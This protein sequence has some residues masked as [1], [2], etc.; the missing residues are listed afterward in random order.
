MEWINVNTS[1]MLQDA[2]TECKRLNPLNKE[3]NDTTIIPK[4]NEYNQDIR[5]F[6]AD[7]AETL[8]Q[9]VRHCC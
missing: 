1:K 4:H 9:K 8:L 6:F 2:V 3:K 5:N 7:N